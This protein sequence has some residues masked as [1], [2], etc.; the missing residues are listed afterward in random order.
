MVSDT[1]YVQQEKVKDKLVYKCILSIFVR[2]FLT[3]R[4]IHMNMQIVMDLLGE[5][6]VQIW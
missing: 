4:L 3:E 5:A 1:L 2:G 6:A